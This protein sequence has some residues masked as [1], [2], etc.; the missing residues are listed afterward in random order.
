[1]QH[2]DRVATELQ[3]LA[4]FEQFSRCGKHPNRKTESLAL[5]WS[6]II[7]KPI[8]GVEPNGCTGLLHRFGQ[9]KHMVEVSVS[10]PD[11]VDVQPHISGHPQQLWDLPAWID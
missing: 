5:L 4:S 1:M 9:A 11:L 7:K 3:L 2:L 10:Q 8:L 6:C